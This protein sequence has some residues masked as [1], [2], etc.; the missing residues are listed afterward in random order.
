MA[1]RPICLPPLHSGAGTGRAYLQT[2]LSQTPGQNDRIIE[3][4]SPRAMT[5]KIIQLE[6]SQTLGEGLYGRY[7]ALF[8]T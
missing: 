2:L 4:S 3:S 7:E 6:F 5:Q 8:S 1:L